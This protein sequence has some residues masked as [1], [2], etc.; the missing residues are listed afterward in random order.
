MPKQD[1]QPGLRFISDI[2]YAWEVQQIPHL[3]KAPKHVVLVDVND[4]TASKLIAASAL[5]EPH[6]FQ[7]AQ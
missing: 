5:L 6:L 7:P 3:K 4:H 2:G 1:I